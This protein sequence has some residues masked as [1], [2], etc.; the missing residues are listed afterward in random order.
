MSYWGRAVLRASGGGFPP[1]LWWPRG[2]SDSTRAPSGTGLM[3]QPRPWHNAPPCCRQLWNLSHQARW[4]W[5]NTVSDGVPVLPLW[6]LQASRAS[7]VPEA[8]LQL[9]T[10][11]L[12]R[13]DVP[14]LQLQFGFVSL[15]SHTGPFDWS[16]EYSQSL[17]S[18]IYRLLVGFHRRLNSCTVEGTYRWCLRGQVY[19]WMFAGFDGHSRAVS[20]CVVPAHLWAGNQS[21]SLARVLSFSPLRFPLRSRNCA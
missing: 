3:R 18:H 10:I 14:K 4:A 15:K 17:Q 21:I 20:T 7:C 6:E 11:Q 12:I 5:T 13:I 16:F 2:P 1:H 8:V 19:S 9:G